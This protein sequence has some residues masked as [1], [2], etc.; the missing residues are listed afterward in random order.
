MTFEIRVGRR[1]VRQIRHAA[2][3][4]SENR[5]K[6]PGA[7]GED[8]E[9]AFNLLGQLPGAGERVQHRTIPLVRRLLLSRVRYLLYYSV[10]EA[11]S[12]VEIIALWHT[13]RGQPPRL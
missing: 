2:D 8:I 6:A 11:S 13:G 10:D 12:V 5:P 4:W 9:S 7:F 1:A 3:W